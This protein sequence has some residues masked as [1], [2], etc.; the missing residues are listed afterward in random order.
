MVNYLADDGERP[1]YYLYD[2]APGQ[3]PAPPANDRRE[4]SI[5]NARRH[6]SDFTL[7]ENGFCFVDE[8]LPALDFFD[9]A[10]VVDSYYPQVTAL[11]SRVTG[12]GRVH[13]FDH[14]VRDKELSEQN[15]GVREPVRFVHNDYTEVSGP[16]RVRDLMGDET[17]ALLQKRYMF[18]NVWRPL[19]GP[20]R[21]YPF[22]ICDATSLT[23]TDFVATDLKYADRTGEIYSV[24]HNPAHR[25]Y[26][27]EGMQDNEIMLLKC[28][29]SNTAGVARYTAHS[30]FRDSRAPHN[31]EPRRSIEVRTI[32]FFDHDSDK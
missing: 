3:R 27:V 22:A 20:V 12:A 31:S 8:A 5:F 7:D 26:Y 15:G 2:T 4:V 16:Q 10:S 23:Q 25:W 6:K 21:D 30:A 29:D 9:Q 14:N 32:A 18:I 11:V 19:R 17:E 1:A 24:K 13:A 28:F